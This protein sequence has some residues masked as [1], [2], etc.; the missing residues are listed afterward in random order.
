[1]KLLDYFFMAMLVAA[2]AV[3][4][5]D[6]DPVYWVTVYTLAAAV[7]LLHTT[8]RYIQFIAALTI[9][10]I[11]SGMIYAAP[12]F[13]AY[14]QSG[15]FSSITASM[16]GAMWYVEPAREFLGLLIALAIVGSYVLRWRMPQK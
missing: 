12:G 16:D 15:R 1:M 5:N 2:A 7:P 10:M 6:P 9:G 3:Q 4:F 13:S 8:G 14:W 11:A